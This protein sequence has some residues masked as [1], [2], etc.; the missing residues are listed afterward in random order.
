MRLTSFTDYTLRELMYLAL[1]QER[2]AM[3]G[4]IADA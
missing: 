4:E 3:V 2:T 1:N